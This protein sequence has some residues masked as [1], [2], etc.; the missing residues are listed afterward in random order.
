MPTTPK[1]EIGVFEVKNFRQ[2]NTGENKLF[3]ERA[4]SADWKLATKFK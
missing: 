2:D 4:A 1:M 3:E